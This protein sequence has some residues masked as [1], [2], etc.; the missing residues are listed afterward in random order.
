MYAIDVKSFLG[1]LCFIYYV[2][3]ILFLLF[4]IFKIHFCTDNEGNTDL[5]VTSRSWWYW[6]AGVYFLL[7]EKVKLNAV[8]VICDIFFPD[9]NII[10]VDQIQQWCI[11]NWT[12][13]SVVSTSLIMQFWAMTLIFASQKTWDIFFARCLL[14]VFVLAAVT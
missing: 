2:H 3:I 12:L 13:L 1:I 6:K 14:L 8:V 9:L 5:L 7:I 10:L 4:M 11:C